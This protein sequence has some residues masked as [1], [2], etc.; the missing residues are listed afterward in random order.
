MFRPSVTSLFHQQLIMKILE[1]D[2]AYAKI[3][4]DKISSADFAM[5][6]MGG[7]QFTAEVQWTDLCLTEESA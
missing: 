5:D 7:A 4:F 3:I 1:C 2:E 6:E